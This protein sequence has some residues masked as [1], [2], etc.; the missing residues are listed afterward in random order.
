V[1]Q[2]IQLQMPSTFG[3]GNAVN[4]RSGDCGE[5]HAE[6]VGGS[7]KVLASMKEVECS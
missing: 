5:A 7:R 3:G 1:V 6:V 2:Q 4:S